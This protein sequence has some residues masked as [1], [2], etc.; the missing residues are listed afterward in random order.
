MRMPALDRQ[1]DREPGKV[2]S[3]KWRTG[4]YKSVSVYQNKYE[5]N[6]KAQ[7]CGHF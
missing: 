2:N 6:G 1:I 3:P 7:V 5:N 4:Q